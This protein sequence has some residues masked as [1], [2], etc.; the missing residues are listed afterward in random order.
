[1]VGGTLHGDTL[2]ATVKYMANYL[3]GI[4]LTDADDK[5]APTIVDYDPKQ[6]STF[7]SYPMIYAKIQDNQYGVGVNWDKTFLIANGDTLNASFDPTNQEIFY[8]L[9]EKDSLARKINIKVWTED[10][11]GNSDSINLF[12]HNRSQ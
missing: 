12:N 4:E 2:E 10:Y 8:D 7:T 3:L 6:D 5:K 9:S 1:M 11:N